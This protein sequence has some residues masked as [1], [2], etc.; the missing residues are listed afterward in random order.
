MYGGKVV[1]EAQVG[2]LYARSLHPYTRGLLSSLPRL[3]Q[4]GQDLTTIEGSPPSLRSAP[5][6]CSFA[7]RCDYAHDRCWKEIP[8]LTEVAFEHKVACW[9]DI[10]NEGPRHAD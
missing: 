6:A 9:W 1:E 4:K 3:D 5:T 2:D 7:P 10:E 8:P